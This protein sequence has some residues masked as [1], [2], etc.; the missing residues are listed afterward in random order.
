VTDPIERFT[1]TGI[2]TG[3]GKERYV[4]LVIAS[5]GFSVEK[6]I[7]PAD[8]VGPDGIGLQ[9]RWNDGA[10]AYLGMMV[11]G[12]PNFFM[13]FG[14][15]SLDGVGEGGTLPKQVEMWAGYV[16]QAIM[17]VLR[18]NAQR[19]EVRPLAYEQYNRRLDESSQGLI[20]LAEGPTARNY[21][22]RGG[23]LQVN[24]PWPHDEMHR[25]LRAPDWDD[26]IIA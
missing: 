12:L 16:A 5:I 24:Y 18:R 10:R 15:N 23:K 7:W 20:W 19:I 25:L 1:R 8:Y 9:Q 14:P 26:L 3:D 17:M 2:V 11:P 22:V 21:W 13:L 6:Y 4:D